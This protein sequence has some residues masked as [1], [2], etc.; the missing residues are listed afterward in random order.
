M[1]WTLASGYSCG[2]ALE[3][4]ASRD[5]GPTWDA[6]VPCQL[7]YTWLTSLPL[8]DYRVDVILADGAGGT[9]LSAHVEVTLTPAQCDLVVGPDCA[10]EVSL[11]LEP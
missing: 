11:D 8:G 9:L 10:Q 3:V 4:I 7:G 6:A 2:G 5:G 1:S